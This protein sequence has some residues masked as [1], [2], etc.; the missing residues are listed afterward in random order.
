M[1]HTCAWRHC[2]LPYS[3]ILAK[4]YS[5]LAR[6]AVQTLP[7]HSMPLEPFAVP[8]VFEYNCKRVGL[9]DA[10]VM[11]TCPRWEGECAT[12]DESLIFAATL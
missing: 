2:P 3:G 11:L 4:I 12:G 8:C 5:G 7:R 1:L 9:P 10:P 6:V